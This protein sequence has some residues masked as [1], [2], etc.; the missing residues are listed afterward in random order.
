MTRPDVDWTRLHHCPYCHAKPGKACT[1][2]SGRPGPSHPSRYH[3]T[4]YDLI[5]VFI[6]PTTPTRT[7][8]QRLTRQRY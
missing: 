4:T 7:W 2:K 1:Y 5:P 6:R 8:W 3:D